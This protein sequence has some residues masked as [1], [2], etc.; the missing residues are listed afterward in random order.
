M[1]SPAAA[2]RLP[3]PK[4]RSAPGIRTWRVS[5]RPGMN[6]S[7]SITAPPPSSVVPAAPGPWR[8]TAVN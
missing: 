1:K 5:V 7:G 4:P 6:T 2:R 8:S 3:P